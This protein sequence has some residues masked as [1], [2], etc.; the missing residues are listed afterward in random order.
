M[1]FTSTAKKFLT[2]YDNVQRA[3]NG[4]INLK[5]L[6]ELTWHTY[7]MTSYYYKHLCMAG[8]ITNKIV[9]HGNVWLKSNNPFFTKANESKSVQLK[10]VDEVAIKKTNDWANEIESLAL[11]LLGKDLWGTRVLEVARDLY[12]ISK[13]M[14]I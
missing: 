1:R 2:A 10:V 13:E 14:R 4:F 11:I 12:E 8:R 7:Q 5:K 9:R 6:S 3:T